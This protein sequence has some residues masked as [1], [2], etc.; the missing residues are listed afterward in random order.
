MHVDHTKNILEVKNVSFAYPGT[1]AVLSDVSLN[2]HVGDYVGIIGPN[3]GGKTTLLKI[4]LGLLRPTRGSIALFGR[5]IR[6]FNDWPVIGYVPQKAVHF[7]VAFPAT[8]EEVV[9]MGR[10]GRRGLVRRLNAEDRSKISQALA[11]VDMSAYKH[12]LI[13]DLSGGQQQRV[14][15]A[16]AL[17]TDPKI[18]FLDEPTVG[19]D[20]SAQEQFYRLLEKLNHELDL[21]LVLVS[22]DIDVIA[23]EATELA[24]INQTLVYHGS[25]KEFMQ[26]EYLKKLYGKNTKFILHDH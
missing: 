15:I 16:R 2:I 4:M 22:H 5:D 8:V 10:I 1:D 7:D 14:F 6:N 11:Q 21:T 17:V 24:C 13:G 9:A 25:P 12:H 20:V 19:V 26:G 3:G 23:N 18:I